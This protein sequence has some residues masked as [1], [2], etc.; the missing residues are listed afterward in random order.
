MPVL[1]GAVAAPDE[2]GG[3]V[4]LR[5]LPAPFRAALGV[6]EL[7]RALDDRAHVEHGDGHLQ[8]LRRLDARRGMNRR[9][10]PSILAADFGRLREQVREVV[11]AGAQVIHVDIMDGHFVPPLSMGPKAVEA[12]RDFDVLLDVH[13]MVERPERHIAEFVR[14]GASNIIVHAEATPHVHY[15]VQAIRE[16][17]CNPGVAITPSTPVEA[18]AEVRSD[19]W[20][21]LCMTVNP[22]WGGQEFIPASLD[23]IRRLRAVIGA[24]V[25]LEVDGGID[26]ETA[27]PC[28]EAGAS[29]F[30]AGTSVFGT[31]DPGAAYREVAT[32]AGCS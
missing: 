9:I 8:P 23:K 28:A 11:D 4:S 31:P 20:S 5:L 22:G 1:R 15:A 2:L 27:W 13:L 29:L 6:P 17:G 32:A 14:A 12:L 18:V 16:A 7:R 26:R 21:V 19:V 25:E 10:A 24:D 30:V 3:T